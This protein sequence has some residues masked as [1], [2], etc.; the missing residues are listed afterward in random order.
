MARPLPDLVLFLD[1]CLGTVEVAEVLRTQGIRVETLLD[2]FPS[3][4]LDQDWLPELGRRGWVLLTKDK[5]V[6]RRQVERD[7][8][9]QA[10]IPSFVLAAGD[11][12]GAAMAGA[13]AMAYPQMRKL[14]RDYLP[15]FVAVV[16]ANGKV[17]MVT[18]PRRRAAI[19][20]D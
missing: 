14:V 12:P 4:T 13:F 10:S 8:M 7:A 17:Q 5:D 19:E 15:P 20:R 9:M 3:G 6:R 18:N 16:R 1:E 11:L 2:H